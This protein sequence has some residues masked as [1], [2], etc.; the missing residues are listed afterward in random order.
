MKGNVEDLQE[1]GNS[2]SFWYWSNVRIVISDYAGHEQAGTCE[3]YN[4]GLERARY[5]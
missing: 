2:T 3:L 1:D 5:P 4:R